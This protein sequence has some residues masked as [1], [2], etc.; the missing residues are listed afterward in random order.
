VKTLLSIA[1]VLSLWLGLRLTFW[2]GFAGADD[3]FYTHY[4]VRFDRP[5]INHWEFR[6]PAILALRGSFLAF[7][8]SE[9]AACVPTLLASFAFLVAVAWFVGWPRRLDWRA[10]A[11]VLLAAVMPLDVVMA[12]YP[13]ANLLSAALVA[14]G[15]V[16]MLKG[17]RLT[18]YLGGTLM[19]VGFL[20][21]E[22]S[23]F[24]VAAF[25]FT[26]LAFD[27]RRHWKP[28]VFTVICSGTLF[29][30]ECA[31]YYL[32]LGEPLA[33][34][35]VAAA[36][37]DRIM[38]TVTD[39][40][41]GSLALF[42][43]WPVQILLFC[44]QFGIDLGLLLI[45]GVFSWR[46]LDRSQ[47]TLF[48]AMF[49]YWFW[50]GYGTQVPWAYQPRSRA[51]HY[52]FPFTL[53]IAA[54]L[55][56]VVTSTFSQKRWLAPP[57]L[58]LILLIHAASL[59]VGGRWGQRVDTSRALLH[60]AQGHP[61]RYYLTDVFTMNEM[62]A[63]NGFKLPPNVVC[64]NGPAVREHLLLNKQWPGSPEHRFPEVH[65][66]AILIN[67]DRSDTFPEPEFMH[68]LRD[69]RGTT[70]YTIPVTYSLA[71]RPFVGFV[72]GRSFTIQRFGGDVV[73]VRPSATAGGLSSTAPG[74]ASSNR[75]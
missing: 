37:T 21:H 69:H 41:G 5:P 23:F 57:I 66:F 54:L 1:V 33:R 14:L 26:A 17:H 10:Q 44:K 74:R 50:L 59:S 56:A 15:S 47:K 43:L 60:Y 22:V 63:V 72:G 71:F 68:Y 48:V 32:I 27:W 2:L 36:E 18:P 75:E 25:C 4:A 8:P 46:K 55:P 39:R 61:D 52:Y 7:G 45:C 65:S 38:T 24:Y 58:A 29:L 20:T 70:L 9:A 3:L 28:V 16:A 19:A 30:V 12:T 64:L 11:S 49:A 67:N 6:M 73:E 35:K 62:Y 51:F 40:H 53:A 31:W 13:G 42:Y 34:Y